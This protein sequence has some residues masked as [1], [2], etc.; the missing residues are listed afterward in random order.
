MSLFK[1]R[2][3]ASVTFL[4]KLQ[5]FIAPHRISTYRVGNKLTTLRVSIAD[6]SSSEEAETDKL[7]EQCGFSVFNKQLTDTPSFT[8]VVYKKD[9]S[10][11]AQN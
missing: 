4:M 8:T 1:S 9:F 7:A 10:H 2:P 6:L 11:E 3:E 5:C